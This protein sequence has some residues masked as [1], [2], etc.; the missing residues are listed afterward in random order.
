MATLF[1]TRQYV[2]HICQHIY[3]FLGMGSLMLFV[4]GIVSLVLLQCMSQNSA[5]PEFILCL[6][7]ATY[8][9]VG[10]LVLFTC[11][12]VWIGF[13]HNFILNLFEQCSQKTEDNLNILV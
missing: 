4:L 13:I 2:E 7:F 11:Y 9:W 10:F 6:N 1:K 12:I 5:S 8:I 3:S